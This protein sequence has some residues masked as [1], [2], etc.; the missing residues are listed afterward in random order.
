MLGTSRYKR[1]GRHRKAARTCTALST[2]VAAVLTLLASSAAAA[3][4]HALDEGLILQG[5]N[6]ACGVA[7]DSKGNL[8]VAAAGN[9]AAKAI[10]IFAPDHTLIASI[11]SANEPCGLA[12]DSDGR[13]YV[14]ETATGEV[15]RYTPDAYPFAGTPTYSGPTVIDASGAAD[16]IA[17][18]ST[19]D[20]LYVAEGDH[21]SYY[22]SDGSLGLDE[23]QVVQPF[24]GTGGTYR[25]KFKGQETGLIPYEASH[26][27]VQSA[28]EGLSTIGSGNV[29]VAQNPLEPDPKSHLV[30]FQ[31]A[32]AATN[33][34]ELVCDT[35]GLTG[36]SP[37]CVVATVSD[38]FNGNIG[39]GE[40][41]GVTGVAVFT[42]GGSPARH[43]LFAAEP[44][45]DRIEILS[46]TD[47]RSFELRAPID[48]SG[49]PYGELGLAAGGAYLGLDSKS[50][51]VFAFD[52]VHNVVNEFEAA[53]T[54]FT[55]IVNGALEDSQPTAI[56]V[57]RSGGAHEG[58][59]YL[60]T[61][62]G[63]LSKVLAFGPVAAPS[64]PSLPE[65]PS[66][67]FEKACGT[68]V[69]AAG[70]VYVAGE[71]II[72]VYSPAG[73]ELA[74][75]PDPGKPCYLAV[76]SECNLYA[77]NLGAPS[78][79]DEKIVLYKPTGC[80]VAG[81]T[82]S[83]KGFVETYANPQGIAVNPANDRLF[84]SH[85]ES[86]GVLEYAS[87]KAGSGLLVTGFC[88]FAIAS[89]GI[90]V[91]GANENVYIGNQ[92][93]ITIC[94]PT[95]SK[96]LAG[97]DGSG[98]PGG[99]FG[100]LGGVSIAV[101][102][103]NGHVLI[104][105]LG[106]RGVIEEFEASGAFV[107]Q[108]G[109][110]AKV[111]GTAD[112]AIDNSSGP[113]RGNLYVAYLKDLTAFGPLEYGGPPEEVVTREA[114]GIGS[115]AATL[116]GSLNPRGF[117]L[118]ECRFEYL[119]EAG[120][121]TNLKAAKPGFEGA[122][123]KPCAEALG[124]IG[125]GFSPTSVHVDINGLEPDGRYRFRLVVANAYGGA[126]SEPPGTFGPPVVETEP[127]QPVF[128][129]EAILR[130]TV[131]PAGLQT[132]YRFEY[133]SE[134]EY[135]ANAESFAGAISTPTKVLPANGGPTDVEASVFGLAEGTAYRFR[136]V[137][138]NADSTAVGT[139]RQFSSLSHRTPSSCPNDTLRLENGSTSLPDCRAYEL[140][141]PA[142]M[143]GNTPLQTEGP[144]F[145]SWFVTPSGPSAGNSLAFSIL[146]TLSN[147]EGTGI[148]D[149]W[150]MHRH[151]EAGMEGW[152]GDLI[153]PSFS[154]IEEGGGDHAKLQ[155]L[156]EE[157]LYGFW[158]YG[159][160]TVR[161]RT[162]DGFEL[163]GTGSLGEDPRAVG[164]FIGP[165][166]RHVL[167]VTTVPC[168][169]CPAMQLEP[170]A[171]TSTG[172]IYDRMPGGKTHVVSLPPQDASAATKAQFETAQ[173]IYEGASADGSSV[174]FK[175]AGNLYLR[176][177][178]TEP[179]AET[180]AV[181]S[182]PLTFAGISQDGDRLFYAKAETVGETVPAASLYSYDLA[183]Q[184]ETP[185][186]VDS[187][188]VNVSADGSRVYFASEQRLD[189]AEK[190]IPGAPNL[191]LWDGSEIGLVAVLAPED[192]FP[193]AG[194][195][196]FPGTFPEKAIGVDDWTYDCVNPSRIGQGRGACPSRS[197]PSGDVLAFQSH[198][199]LTDYEARGHSEI[200]RY[201]AEADSLLCVSCDPSGIPAS[202]DAD[203][204]S[205][206]GPG[207]LPV[208]GKSL[209]PSLTDNGQEIFFQ[210]KAALLPE[211][212]NSALD[213][214]EWQAQGT[215]ECGPVGG[216]LALIS[217]GQGERDS[218]IYAMTPDGHDVF[219]TT[220]DR[221]IESDVVGSPSIYD[222]RIGGGFRQ[223]RETEPCHGDAC[224][225]PPP[226]TPERSVTTTGVPNPG[227]QSGPRK[228]RC[229]KGQRMV[230]RSGK[231][232]CVKRHR[233]HHRHGADTRRP[234]R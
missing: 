210:T 220:I 223:P 43:Y 143:R 144:G 82:Y 86:P 234:S 94:D 112:L 118:S 161:L 73:S 14:S 137:A 141:T 192:L 113:T 140:V 60:T 16:G 58:T 168:G 215:S 153:G 199:D 80:P 6:H 188:F 159:G 24:G 127:A 158:S 169:G 171:P 135:E 52:A 46:G 133:L 74:S 139:I 174:V 162:P 213:V 166:G 212:A 70:N 19:D 3:P 1:F 23:A 206:A 216:C 45:S 59:V 107:A 102:Q 12:V 110:F 130:G 95:G 219:F 92:N 32:L 26:A 224:Q 71:S 2:A 173:P 15:V 198:A 22:Q 72:K 64:R 42:Y 184:T 96:R 179:T 57:D 44:A 39:E 8:Y 134:A 146:G 217:S 119:S 75:I 98:S 13:L 77:A 181:A 125:K 221:L 123:S 83:E 4:T 90:D 114:S 178:D 156:S 21:V 40:L 100:N 20:S 180:I 196:N 108:F 10:E 145:N 157:Q 18:D 200:Y 175:V 229:R 101:D 183:T 53:G 9:T 148:W 17:I 177:Q 197:T 218:A 233:N 28:L 231:R 160:G 7:V 38:G 69:D 190:G 66:R 65:P 88:G 78:S 50:G 54:Y 138:E 208:Q 230:K 79:G 11:E 36:V 124:E 61:G 67:K 41:G 76:D 214:Y 165:G 47:V 122:Q 172:A 51:H 81:T 111:G 56:V 226:S 91:Y 151:D 89:Y 117:D 34:E 109:S 62:G 30:N 222:A 164:A 189:D 49:T 29:S 27:E 225:L 228:R 35:S 37:G 93:R 129:D 132:Q 121:Q 115:G 227:N 150:R 85:L 154:E 176:R 167:F 211:D 149:A 232:R 55:R 87:A 25:L 202:A 191:Y 126:T 187:K 203:F 163:L 116:N 152:F 155:A 68:V 147:A 131:D 142:D 48:G 5:F 97:I 84:V 33:T 194:A 182:G 186:A 170:S 201:D 120:Y 209:I 104:G 207:K 204:E 99:V 193:G 63:A 106:A 136:L 103:A 31:G 205:F 195:A 105:E 185:I 128:Y